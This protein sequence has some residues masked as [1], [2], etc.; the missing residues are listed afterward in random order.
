MVL[1][2]S[3]FVGVT[4]ALIGPYAVAGLFGA[5]AKRPI[6]KAWYK[7]CT[8][9]CGL[10]VNVRG[11]PA[12]AP[13]TLFAANH[14]SYLDI[15]V[16]G[17]LIDGR[18]VAKSDVA[19]WPLFGVLSKMA[20][21]VFVTRDRRSAARDGQKLADMVTAGERLILFPEGTSSNGRS[22]LPFRSTLFAAAEPSRCRPETTLQP[23]TLAYTVD[24]AGRPL[25][26]AVGDCYAWYGDM[27]LF[28]HLMTVFGLKG[29]SLTLTFHPPVRPQAFAD[30]K[31]LAA[32]AEHAVRKGL[33]SSI[34]ND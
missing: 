5:R 11:A 6:A 7:T 3:A 9:I 2:A 33:E 27:T 24:A 22:V 28:G 8:S 25:Q 15:I 1:R 34:R 29:A 19:D 10:K 32:A 23:V 26:G 21:T 4:A 18:F 14:V 20:D 31:A 16:L 17:A 12:D 30:R 13:S